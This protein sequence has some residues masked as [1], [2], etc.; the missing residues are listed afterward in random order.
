VATRLPSAARR[1]PWHLLLPLLLALPACALD[2]LPNRW[3]ADLP[4]FTRAGERMLSGQWAATFAHPKLQAGPLQ[5]LVFGGVGKLAG[6][7]G[8]APGRLLAPLVELAIVA[9][10]L[11][12]L[13]RVVPDGQY[14]RPAL[15]AI[16]VLV[17]LLQEPSAVY[18]A[19][20]PADAVTPLLWLLAA[21]EARAGRVARAGLLLGAGASLE[22][23]SVLG[24]P[25][26]LLAPRLRDAFRGGLVQLAATAAP[27]LPFLIAGPFRMFD[28][29]WHV[30]SG[31]LV[32]V[33][34]APDTPFPWTWRL[35]QGTLALAAGVLVVRLSRRRPASVALVPLAVVG[36]RLVLDPMSGAGYYAIAFAL[37]AMVAAAFAAEWIAAALAPRR[38]LPARGAA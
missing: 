13:D 28:Y 21:R 26:L 19:G 4:Y 32:S 31:S 37:L 36:V 30:R 10:L 16:P 20:H 15:L 5:L 8:V 25:V 24:A 12:T 34:L 3:D 2:G 35:A 11:V 33:F 9:F 23:W 17:V 6:A 22:V 29:R 27:F 38:E 18:L 1:I 7:V 14:R